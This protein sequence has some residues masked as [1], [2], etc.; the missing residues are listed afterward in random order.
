MQS[1][2][3]GF[4]MRKRSIITGLT[5]GAAGAGILLATKARR[6]SAPGGDRWS[7]GTRLGVGAAAGALLG[8]AADALAHLPEKVTIMEE[9]MPKTQVASSYSQV[10][11]PV[12]AGFFSD[13]G[14]GTDYESRPSAW[15]GFITPIDRF[16]LRSHSPTPTIDISSWSLKIEGTG[17]EIPVEL[18]YAELEAM[19]QV[20]LTRTMECAGNG[21]RFYKEHF[22]VEGEGGQWRMGAMG[23]AEWTGVRLRDVLQRAGVKPRARDVMPIGLDEHEVRRPM[24]VEKA[25]RDDTLL[26]LKMNGETLPIDH[27]FPVRILVTGWTGT[28]SIKWVGRIQVAEESLHSPYNTMEYTMVGPNY[29]ME[30]PALGPPITEMPVMS[31]LDLDWPAKIS[32]QTNEIYGRSF[33]GEGRVREVVYSIDDD[34]WKTAELIG[35]NIEGCWRQWKFA[36]TPTAG[37]HEIRVRA[38][39]ENGRT[40][41]DTVPWNHHGYLYNAVVAHPITVS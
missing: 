20:T 33:A 21:R 17:V 12:P 10:V 2:S 5:A 29:P 6:S 16:Y 30:F 37:K 27:G 19:P 40:Q 23:C 7:S 34:D 36:W 22:G 41:P 38:T 35:P 13:K 28:A 31:V 4:L 14:S 15:G 3:R 11:K 25:M 8:F 9:L 24:P 18:S 32:A 39:D 26:V 1:N